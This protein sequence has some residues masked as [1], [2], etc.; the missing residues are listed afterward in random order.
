MHCI[1]CWSQQN[2]CSVNEP[3]GKYHWTIDLLCLFCC[4]AYVDYQQ[5]YMF[6]QIQISQTE[7][8]L[9]SDTYPYGECYLAD[10]CI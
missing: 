2:R 10:P 9:Y 6:S 4:F 5:L 1:S 3:K 7:G 8:Q